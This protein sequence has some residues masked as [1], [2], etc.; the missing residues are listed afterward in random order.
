[1]LGHGKN[2]WTG[3]KVTREDL[4][5]VDSINRKAL[6]YGILT[7]IPRTGKYDFDFGF[8]EFPYCYG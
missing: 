7:K 3:K 1:M 8:S 6:L 5:T 4:E 2:V